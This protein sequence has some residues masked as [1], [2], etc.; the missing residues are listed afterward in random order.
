MTTVPTAGKEWMKRAFYNEV[1]SAANP[2]SDQ[3]GAKGNIMVYT[4]EDSMIEL[5]FGNRYLINLHCMDDKINTN[6]SMIAQIKDLIPRIHSWQ[7]SNK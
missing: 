4:D 2:N 3:L 7:E 1:L 5:I 6:S